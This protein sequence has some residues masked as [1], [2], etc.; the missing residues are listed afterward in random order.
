MQRLPTSAMRFTPAEGG[1]IGTGQAWLL[2]VVTLSF[3]NFYCP[4]NP[5]VQLQHVLP[6]CPAHSLPTI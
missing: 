5:A 3:T 4:T 2:S 6:S 1:G